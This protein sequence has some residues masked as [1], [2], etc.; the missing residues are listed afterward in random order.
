ML[1]EGGYLH[2]LKTLLEKAEHSTPTKPPS[3]VAA[4]PGRRETTAER[5]GLSASLR[6]LGAKLMRRSM[7]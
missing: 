1:I 5:R 7:N 6:A 3:P 4:P 2:S